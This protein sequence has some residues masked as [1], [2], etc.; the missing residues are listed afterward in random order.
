MKKLFLLS[1]FFIFFIVIKSVAQT[2]D[3][4]KLGIWLWYLDP[5]TMG[6]KTHSALAKDLATAGIKGIY[7]KT[8]DSK[9]N[10]TLWPELLD[11]RYHFN[12]AWFF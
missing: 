10:P 8:A 1:T 2:N 9:P 5:A 3:C 6:Y 12:T 11:K 7:V 4:N